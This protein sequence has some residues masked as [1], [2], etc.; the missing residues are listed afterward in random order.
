MSKSGN[1]ASLPLLVVYLSSCKMAFRRLQRQPTNVERN[2][3]RLDVVYE[4]GS[5]PCDCR[6]GAEGLTASV[7]IQS[8]L[9]GGTIDQLTCMIR[10]TAH[11]CVR[12]PTRISALLVLRRNDPLPADIIRWLQ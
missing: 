3:F 9:K 7:I 12:V 2:S 6:G 11:C 4:L 10:F 5:F 8:N 1:A